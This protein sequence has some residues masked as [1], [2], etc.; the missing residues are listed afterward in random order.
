MIFRGPHKDIE[1]PQAPLTEF[2]FSRIKGREDKP[3]IIDGVTGRTLTFAQLQDSIMRVAVGMAGRGIAKGDVV[4]IFSPNLPEYVIAFHAVA[5]LGGVVTTINPTYTVDEISHQLA[6][7]RPKCLITIPPLLE[8]AADAAKRS[9]ALELVVFGQA[10]GA[11][12]FASL[13]ASEGGLPHVEIDAREDVVALPFSSGTTGVA[14]GVMLTHLNCVANLIQLEQAGYH[15]PDETV[16]CVLPL[17]HIYGLQAVMHLGLYCGAT[18]ITLPRFDFEQVLRT[19]E[20]HRISM[21]HIVPPIVLALAKS[22]LVDNFDLSSLKTIFSGA[23]PLGAEVSRAVAERLGCGVSQGYGMTEASPATHV[24]P[25]HG[26]KAGSVGPPMPSTEC[27][28]V[29]L[30]TGEDVGQGEKGEICVR[31][32]QVMKGY[33]NSPEATAQ[34]IDSDGWLH[35]GDIGYADADEYFYIVDRAKELIK[36]KG[37]QVAPAELEALLHAHAAIADAA[38]IP[39]PDEACGDVPKAYVVVRSGSQVTADEIINFIAEQVAPHKK[40]R[41]VEFVDEIPKS[42]S[43]KILR[44]LLVARE[45]ERLASLTS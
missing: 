15:I 39:S 43:G 12:P 20:T 16:L 1:I 34:T 11:T 36:Y 41:L 35:T 19:I 33:L 2:M 31:G 27:R 9:S 5:T 37:F 42:P 26:G 7:A 4:A 8:K 21:L 29:S 6:H 40:I 32:P 18:V 24:T 30:E 23:A 13:F 28:V 10:E 17:F 45:R 3:A 22:P 25:R 44:R 38:V 14:K